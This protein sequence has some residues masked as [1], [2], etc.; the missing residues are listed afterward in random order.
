MPVVWQVNQ[1]G[2]KLNM[3]GRIESEVLVAYVRKKESK[4]VCGEVLIRATSPNSLKSLVLPIKLSS[5]RSTEFSS[6][7]WRIFLVLK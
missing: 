5:I 4:R 3:L 1:V 7:L 6:G 2:S